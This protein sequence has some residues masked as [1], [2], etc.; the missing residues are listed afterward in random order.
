MRNTDRV[1]GVLTILFGAWVAYLSN[2]MVLERR[3]VPG[4]GMLPLVCGLLLVL[5]GLILVA[6]P[7]E[8]GIPV[9]WPAR[10]D[11][12]RVVGSMV[13]LALFTIAVPYLGFTLTTFLILALLIWWW[14]TYHIWQAA[15]IGAVLAV[16]MMVV[17][18]VL[19]GAPL[20]LGFWG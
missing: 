16:G 9:N 10:E 17:F 7:A 12:I 19:L 18:Q 5:F 11:G 4:P 1:T 20:P 2:N 13:A 15:V 14:G 3:G 6:R 8:A